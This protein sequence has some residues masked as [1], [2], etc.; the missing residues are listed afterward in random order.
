MDKTDS[1]FIL[2][3]SLTKA[4]KRYFH[5]WSNLQSGDKMY[6][7]L[8]DLF[9]SLETPQQVHAQFKK[10]QERKSFD[11]ACKYLY[12]ILLDCLVKLREKQ[13][14]QT[15]IYNKIAKAGILFERDLFEN[16]L[17][18]LNKAKRLA[19]DYDHDLLLHLI[20][21][22]ELRYLSALDFDGLSERELVNKQLKINEVIKYS[23]SINQ[24]IQLYDILKHRL[25]YKD[26]ARSDKQREELNDL[27]LSELHLIANS[28]YNGF[29]AEKM[30]VLFQATYYLNSGKYELAIRY[31]KQVYLTENLIF[32][33][34]QDYPLPVYE[35]NR[36]KL[37]EKYRKYIVKIQQSKY[38][39]HLL[40]TFD[41]IAWI[42]SK[43]KRK[44][45]QE[46]IAKNVNRIP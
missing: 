41:F 4:E 3:K 20:R 31:K 8:F 9:D 19:N 2:V 45:F 16:A 36:L 43:L 26:Y 14:A 24:H 27:V 15:A 23:R 40:K 28:S 34:V 25:F 42:E 6:L 13:D 35:K 37:W 44:P 11:I 39:R 10:N 46:I 21:R 22:T 7:A 18:E 1:L 33:F 12:K 30:H 38:E 32:K 17:D 29:E 5:L